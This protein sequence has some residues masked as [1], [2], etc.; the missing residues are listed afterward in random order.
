MSTF[1]NSSMNRKN[2]YVVCTCV[3]IEVKILIVLVIFKTYFDYDV[4][5]KSLGS[6]LTLIPCRQSRSLLRGRAP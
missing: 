4:T 2:I 5:K 3:C 6:P 1:R